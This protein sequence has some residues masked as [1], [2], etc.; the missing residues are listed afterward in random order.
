MPPVIKK[1]TEKELDGC[2]FLHLI[3]ATSGLDNPRD[4]QVIDYS[5]SCPECKAGRQIKHPVIIPQNSMGKKKIDQ[6]GR[7]GFLIFENDL[8]GELKANKIKGLEFYPAMLGK[9]TSDFQT[10][11]IINELPP[12]A[13]NSVILKE[14][15]CP[16][17]GRSGHFN[18]YNKINEYRYKTTVLDSISNDFYRTWEYF[19]WWERGAT[20]QLILISQKTR[21]ILKQFKLR[22]LQ[23]EPIFEE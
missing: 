13:I 9:N 19:G 18:Y 7:Y 3:I 8:I 16:T 15:V 6:N 17:C 5:N 12:F 4:N 1:Y 20:H 23:F 21:Q 22:H 2:R 10:G 14:H 11:H